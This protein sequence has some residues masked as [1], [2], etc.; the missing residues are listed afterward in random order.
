MEFGQTQ[1]KILGAMFLILV[2]CLS[3]IAFATSRKTSDFPPTIN[4][5]P[6]FFSFDGT[7]CVPPEGIYSST[8][9]NSVG[10]IDI[11]SESSPFLSSKSDSLCKKKGWAVPLGV[12]WDGI[13]NNSEIVVC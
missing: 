3:L 2:I 1:Q 10:S 8:G 4:Q 13:T 11:M 12:T 9:T 7:S 5:C 6:D